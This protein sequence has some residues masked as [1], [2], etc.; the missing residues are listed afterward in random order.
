MTLNITGAEVNKLGTLL[1]KYKLLD[2]ATL[3]YT[4]IDSKK[5][6][7]ISLNGARRYICGLPAKNLIDDN[8]VD[9]NFSAELN[10]VKFPFELVPTSN[11]SKTPL[12]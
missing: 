12:P 6:A 11:K 3:R 9:G 1:T 7:Y 8:F 4:I 10:I 2:D 5:C